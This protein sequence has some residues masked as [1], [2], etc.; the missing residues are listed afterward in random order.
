M[1]SVTAANAAI[2][3][4]ASPHEPA[5]GL[6]HGV[7]ALGLGVPGE[8][9]ALADRVGVLQVEGDAVGHRASSGRR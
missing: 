7:E 5:L 2:G 4:V 3:T 9:H 6:P 8:L 1:R